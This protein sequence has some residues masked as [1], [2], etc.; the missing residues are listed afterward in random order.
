MQKTE[1]TTKIGADTSL[2]EKEDMKE[3]VT[4]ENQL[5]STEDCSEMS[6]DVILNEE[7]SKK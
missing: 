7:V 2:Y 5:N 4:Q 6:K 3:D 1:Q